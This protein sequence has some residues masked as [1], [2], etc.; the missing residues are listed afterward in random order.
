MNSYIIDFILK[1]V[2]SGIEAVR[3]LALREDPFITDI[4]EFL[5]LRKGKTELP[6]RDRILYF[7]LHSFFTPGTP[8][9]ILENRLFV[10]RKILE[11][12]IQLIDDFSDYDI[13]VEI[14][15]I[16]ALLKEPVYYSFILVEMNHY[17]EKMKQQNGFLSFPHEKTV[18]ECIIAAGACEISESRPLLTDM[19]SFTTSKSIVGEARRVLK[20]F[21]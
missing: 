10:N 15:R 7:L 19:I 2:D 9:D 18:I 3:A 16:I 8:A 13:K 1:D 17:L 12:M 5:V 6:Y 14:I 21:R 4:L 11:T 20:Q